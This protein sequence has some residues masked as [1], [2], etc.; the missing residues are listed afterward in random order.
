MRSPSLKA[1]AILAI[2]IFVVGHAPAQRE[3]QELQQTGLKRLPRGVTVSKLKKHVVVPTHTKGIEIEEVNEAREFT[4][5][6]VVPTKVFNVKPRL[7]VEAFAAAV[8][9]VMQGRTAGYIMQVRQNGS[10]IANYVWEWAQTPSNLSIPWT[11]N[12]RM[13]VASVS[14]LLTA[15]GMVKLLDSKGISY[16]AKIIDYL[17]T[18]W[19]KGPNVDKITFRHLLTHRSGFGGETSD[20]D[21]F[22]MQS[23]VMLGVSSPGSEKDY[24][25]M[26]F[27]LMRIL[28]PIINGDI[29][30]NHSW[31]SPMPRN[32]S[33]DAFTIDAYKEYMQDKVFS[34]AGV[35]NADFAT[36]PGAP[37]SALAYAFP[38]GNGWDSGNLGTVAGG[39]AWRL[40][41]KEL[42][43]VM[44]HFRRKNTIIDS[45][46]A[47]YMLDNKFGIDQIKE[48]PAGNIYNKNGKW[49]NN[50][51]A[52]Q[53]VAYFFPNGMEVAVFVNSPII[54]SPIA[55]EKISL[56]N[57]IRDAFLASLTE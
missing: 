24:E 8:H 51:R 17:P 31:P 5:Q 12:T 13:H 14:K 42:L 54:N 6:R 57:T 29:S 53:S 11:E 25:N 35:A 22:F 4:F 37:N 47:Q 50:G 56:R 21:Y 52:E 40:S 55:P 41:L 26:N 46:K 38:A 16:D 43:D 7:N 3:Q 36:L 49:G 1:F 48:T 28:I 32:E 45:Q 23:K 30:K 34:P 18:Y 27:G 19:V 44:N 10:P 20:S 2:V 33:W 39:A 9:S 15:I